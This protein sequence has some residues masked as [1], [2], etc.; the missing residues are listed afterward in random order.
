MPELAGSGAQGPVAVSLPPITLTGAETK[1][2]IAN[3][4]AT[5][6]SADPNFKS[7]SGFPGRSVVDNGDGTVS[8]TFSKADDVSDVADPLTGIQ[9]IPLINITGGT[10]PLQAIEK[11]SKNSLAFELNIDGANSPKLIDLSYLND[12]AFTKTFTGVDIAKEITNQINKSYG[13]ERVFDFTQGDLPGVDLAKNQN[14]G[15]L[16]KLKLVNPSIEGDPGAELNI[17]FG[18]VDPALTPPAPGSQ[19]SKGADGTI[20]P[21]SDGVV[22]FNSLSSVSREDALAAIQS[23]VKANA[24]SAAPGH[25]RYTNLQVAYDS[26]L[27]TFTFKN[28][29]ATSLQI[30]ASAPNLPIKGL[31]GLTSTEALV[32]SSTGG[33]GAKVIPNGNLI[34]PLV[35]QRYGTIVSFDDTTRRFTISSGTTGDR[36]SL[37]V[38]SAS[39]NAYTLL[40]LTKDTIATS[41]IPFRGV[42][43]ESAK[44]KGGTIGLNLDNKFRV[45]ATNNQFVVTVDNVTGLIE[46]PPKADYTIEGFRQ[47][48]ENRINA[49]GDN[50]GRTV[51]GAKVEIMTN[52]NGTKYF[53]ISTGTTGND[54]FLKVSG[55]SIWGLNGLD[56]VRG[57]TNQW[58]D[59]K[60]AKNQDGFPLYVSRD[61]N[62]TTDPGTFSAD[63]TRDLWAPVFYDNGE[64]TFNNKGDLISPGQM[65][66][67]KSTT[68]GSSGSTLK[69][70]IDYGVSTQY[71]SPFSI[72][73]QDQNGRPEGDLIGVDIA[74]NGLVNASY[75]NGMTKSLAK[76]ILANFA[77]PTGLRQIGDASFY[78][79]S[80]S[81]DVKYGEA[82]AAGF[83]TVRAGARERANV[84]LTN[85]LVDLITAQRNFQA[86]AKAIETNNTLTSAIINIRG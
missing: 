69:F 3:L 64:L 1:L 68:I 36:S 28:T 7:A 14:I 26:Q 63:E 35:E 46:I 50:F 32:D 70:S 37:E 31:M 57:K 29:S 24:N 43:S 18:Q 17:Q 77:A 13:D 11:Y 78:A 2:E 40:G 84:D 75:S 30:F 61:G 72:K 62:E 15:T 81:G 54:S 27:Q 80:K 45:D 4:I 25:D 38:T 5:T 34:N 53:Q 65:I 51:N 41:A 22:Y 74:D 9:S 49:L 85:E 12:E 39:A 76:I 44:L 23:I 60:Q 86:N 48:L 73:K 82:G 52:A 47:E 83:G 16:M 19:A 33:Y 79:T 21:A 6:I 59:P 55:N 66:D 10:A 71:S 8:I 58:Q 20:T 56:S 67:F 42:S